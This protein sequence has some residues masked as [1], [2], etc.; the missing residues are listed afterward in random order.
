MSD[1]SSEQHIHLTFAL[2]FEGVKH[3]EAAPAAAAYAFDVTGGFI[4]K[5]HVEDGRASLA[6][7]GKFANQTVRFFFGP[8]SLREATPSISGLTRLN[9]YELRQRVD[10]SQPIVDLPIY[11]PIWRGWLFCECVVTGQLVTNVTLP[12]GVTKQ[13][14]ICNA[15]VNICEVWAPAA[16]HPATCLSRSLLKLRDAVVN[17]DRPALADPTVPGAG[18]TGRLRQPRRCPRPRPAPR[19]C[20]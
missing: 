8:A 5:A 13:L 20:R 9:G 1:T 6:L 11:D 3:G 16:D 18:R 19:R 14:P 12:S 2:R 4:A 17:L 7:P 15:R 10:A